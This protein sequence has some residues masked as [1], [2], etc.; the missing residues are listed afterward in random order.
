[1][2]FS[3]REWKIQYVGHLIMIWGNIHRI[4]AFDLCAWDNQTPEYSPGEY[5]SNDKPVDY[6]K[7]NYEPMVSSIYL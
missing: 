2:L 4:F 3:C 5:T 6:M 7:G 1:M